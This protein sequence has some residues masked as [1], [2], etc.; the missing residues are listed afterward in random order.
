M[1]VINDYL[2]GVKR[3]YPDTEAVREQIEELRDTL[4]LKTEDLQAQGKT[5]DEAA[6]EAIESIGDVTPLFDEVSGNVRTVYIN[7]L[8]KNNALASSALLYVVFITMWVLV[9]LTTWDYLAGAFVFSAFIL[10]FGL[11]IWVLI[12]AI[13][14]K[15]EP[16]KTALVEFSYRKQMRMALFGWLS[17]SIFLFVINLMTPS[18]VWFFYPFIGIANWPLSIFIYHKQL[19]GGRYDAQ[20]G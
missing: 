16:K 17:L 2:N 10:F 12:T 9:L 19:T 14:Y 1:S 3:R 13:S 6:R 15:R 18:S 11:G 7:R 8:R 4:H 5:Y 20:A